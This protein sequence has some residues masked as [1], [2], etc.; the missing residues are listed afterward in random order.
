VLSAGAFGCNAIVRARCRDCATI[1][2]PGVNFAEVTDAL[3]M[4][5]RCGRGNFCKTV[6][7][8][9][10]SGIL[11][12]LR[13]VRADQILQVDYPVNAGST[14]EARKQLEITKLSVPRLRDQ[15]SDF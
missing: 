12:T 11:Q 15:L 13:D 5:F 4:N 6:E 8:R 9:W 3:E 7:L 2:A 14:K 10:P 1:E